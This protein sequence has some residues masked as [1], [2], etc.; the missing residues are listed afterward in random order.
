METP[1]DVLLSQIRITDVKSE[2]M[3][4][5]IKKLQ[6]ELDKEFVA[7]AQGAHANETVP[8]INLKTLK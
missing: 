7:E 1:K 6:I 5:F 4:F 2:R 8:T 3:C